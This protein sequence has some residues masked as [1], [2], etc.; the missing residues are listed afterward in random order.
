MTD[1]SSPEH[2]PG[3]ITWLEIPVSDPAR[4]QAFYLAVL[5]FEATPGAPQPMPGYTDGVDGVYMF[6]KGKMHG[7]FVKMSRPEGIANVADEGY[8]AKMPV[9][10][11]YMVESL[12][13]TLEVVEEKGGKR[14]M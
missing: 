6:T 8:V 4:A 14:H 13:K 1:S 5:G 12:E 2:T 7:A 9:L 11:T 3:E 10:P